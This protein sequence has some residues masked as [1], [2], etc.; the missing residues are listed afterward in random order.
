M[1]DIANC[2]ITWEKGHLP[3]AFTHLGCNMLATVLKS[4]RAVQRAIQI[5]RTFTA[6]ESGGFDRK[7]GEIMERLDKMEIRQESLEEKQDKVESDLHFLLWENQPE[8]SPIVQIHQRIRR[9]EERIETL[10]LDGRFRRLQLGE[11]Y[12]DIVKLRESVEKEQKKGKQMAGRLFHQEDQLS[13]IGR[14][15]EKL[16]EKVGVLLKE[17]K[18]PPKELPLPSAVTQRISADQAET[19]RSLVHKRAKGKRKKIMKIWG[20]FK[21]EFGLTRYK[22]LPEG[23]Y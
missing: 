1:N 2:D 12:S 14:E 3:K 6:L 19:L 15:I 4:K 22:L 18:T 11:I 20:D 5:I 23:Q 21:R 10:F 8:T 9:I 13:R 7:W 16:E 17:K